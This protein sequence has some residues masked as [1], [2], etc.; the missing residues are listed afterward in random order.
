MPRVSHKEDNGPVT[1]HP[2]YNSNGL[3]LTLNF[4]FYIGDFPLTLNWVC[5][6][7][8]ELWPISEEISLILL[9]VWHLSRTWIN[10]H[11]HMNDNGNEMHTVNVLACAVKQQGLRGY[12]VVSSEHVHSNLLVCIKTHSTSLCHVTCVLCLVHPSL[13]QCQTKAKLPPW[14]AVMLWHSLPLWVN[15]FRGLW[16]DIICI[17]YR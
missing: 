5:V 4:C 10:T 14:M 7:S 13:F 8:A 3:P 1:I 11:T 12:Q 17:T 6:S 2:P 16:R 15:F 9:L